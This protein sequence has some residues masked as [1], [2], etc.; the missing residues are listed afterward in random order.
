MKLLNGNSAG[1]EENKVWSAFNDLDIS[2]SYLKDGKE[3]W[4]L[5]CV[6]EV[7]VLM[8]LLI[9]YIMDFHSG[10]Q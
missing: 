1:I 8:N 10:D 4:Y 2:V 6:N 5:S 7:P 9:P 3:A